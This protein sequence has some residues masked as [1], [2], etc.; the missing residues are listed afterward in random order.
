MLRHRI[1]Q[2]SA[3]ALVLFL[4]LGIGW[5]GDQPAAPEAERI[6]GLLQRMSEQMTSYVEKFS[7]VKCS[8]LVTQEKFKN[9]TSNK[10][11]LKEQ[12]SY[13][14]LVI[15]TNTG[16]DLNLS[17]SR[18]E[19]K[20]A[21][22]DKKNR[23][24]LV[25]NGFATLFL[26]FHPMYANSFVFTPMEDEVVSG[27]RLTKIGFKHIPGTKTPAALALRGKEYPLELS[28]VAW[29]DPETAELT[30]ITAGVD[31]T[32]EDVGLKTLRSEV[33]FAPIP[34][35]DL[36]RDYW[37][38]ARASVEVE[39]PR[40]HWRNTHEFSNYKRFSVST[41]EQVAKD[42]II[43]NKDKDKDKVSAQ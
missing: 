17:E 1:A 39:T 35:T 26:V 5:A 9:D 43:E 38:P 34:F 12:S 6:Q 29:V 19:V 18:L 41:E 36:K 7:D 10:V 33:E 28:G 42:K 11:E 21:K 40:Q 27:R 8:E 30:R 24:M 3:I 31:K 25:S 16:G 2:I 23:S 37:F 4:G 20:E 15:L 32:L 14:Y 13:D 22:A